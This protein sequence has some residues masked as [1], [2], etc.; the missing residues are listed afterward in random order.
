MSGIRTGTRIEQL[1]A[2]RSRV[3]LE[4][5]Y[6]A[7]TG[8]P[9]E[10]LLHLAG[11]IDQEI[12]SEGGKPPPR[13]PYEKRKRSAPHR[14]DILI[15]ELGVTSAD[16]RAWALAAGIVDRQRRGRLPAVVVE[17]YAANHGWPDS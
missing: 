15:A 5:E 16:V 8:K 9:R 12:R 4:L 6:A 13:T 11:Q 2:L 14:A 1:A 3:S 17:A 10:R 7:R